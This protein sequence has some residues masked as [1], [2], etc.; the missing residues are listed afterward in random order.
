MEQFLQR[1]L[2]N[3]EY[4]CQKQKNTLPITRSFCLDNIQLSIADES[5]CCLFD[6]N[7]SVDFI[8]TLRFLAFST[9]S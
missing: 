5:V 9:Y 4:K 6:Q 7:S 8:E 1:S 3:E 2:G